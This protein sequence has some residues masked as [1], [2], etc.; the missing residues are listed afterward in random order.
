MQKETEIQR[1]ICDWLNDQNYFFWR[2]NNVPVWTDGK[3]RA[4]PKYSP[5]GLADI[6]ILAQGQFIA[7]EVKRPKGFT[8][9]KQ[10]MEQADFGNKVK[11][12]GGF[13]FIVTSLDEVKKI[14]IENFF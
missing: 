3:F 13:Y 8:N 9:P 10:K 14:C 1:E 5:K 7:L 6:I 12:H 4:M 11:S 2:S